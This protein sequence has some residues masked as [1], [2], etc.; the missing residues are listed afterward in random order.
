MEGLWRD[1]LLSVRLLR[2]SPIFTAAA[3][4]TLALGVAAN[5]AVFSVVNAFILRPLPVRDADRLVVLATKARSSPTL[6]G[7]SFPDVQDYRAATS[8]VFEDVTAYS[9]GFLGV[10]IDGDRP[11][12]V[13]VT[14][15]ADNYFPLLDLQPSLGRLI[16]PDEAGP[17]R[18]SAIVVLGHATWQRRFGSDPAVVGR[19]VRVNGHLCTIVGVAPP[20]F[21]G[22]FAFSDSELYL[23][24]DW[25][26]EG[27]FDNRGARGLHALARLRPGVSIA[28][29][30]ASIDVVAARLMKE[31]PVT[32]DETTVRVLP[33]RLARPEE[34]Q[35]RSNGWGA[36]IV[37]ILVGLV[38]GLAG[39]NVTSL[40]LARASSRQQ[41][42]ATRV[43]L[44]AGHGRLVRQM[45]TEGLLLAG[46]G[47]AAGIVIGT[48][49][50]DALA[51]GLLRLPGDLP[52]R[53][54][55]GLD[56]RVLAYAVV[57]ALGTG[58]AVSF[59]AGVR[60]VSTLDLT[61]RQ[62]GR[63]SPAGGGRRT[64]LTILVVQV[65]ACF[66]V[67]VAAGLLLRSLWAAERANLGFSPEGVLTVHMDVGQ[68]GYTEAEGRAFFDDVERRVLALPGVETASFAFTLPMGYIR[69]S[70][71]VEADGTASDVD[72][73]SAGKNIVSRRYFETLRIRIARGR[74]FDPA[75]GQR[76]RRVAVVNQCLA[77]TLWPGQDPVGRRFRSAGGRGAWI[78]VVGVTDTGKYRFLFEDPQP[79]FYVP[80]AQEYT[81]LRVLQ[82]RTPLRPE[83]LAPAIE[84][85]L[86]AREPN[87]TLYDV[88]SMAQALGGGLGFFLVRVGA[89]TAATLG[90]LG[91][92]LAIVGVYGVVAQATVQRRHEMGVRMALGA[93]R[94]D[95]LQLILR[96]GLKLL[97]LGLG[98]GLIIALGG[99]SILERFLFGVSS[100]DA[101]TF[102]VVSMILACV[103]MVACAIPAWHAT[104]MDP[105]VA[106]RTE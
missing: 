98:A 27:E 64:G 50:A 26:G 106:L 46:L 80:I 20:G 11:E 44:G 30:Q 35:A 53:F 47:A 56:W 62:S 105:T 58:L 43:S 5:V 48:W 61:L 9:V 3:A 71:T 57:V 66:V 1:L 60:A 7:V 76:S 24:L 17:G 32:N 63:R 41:E 59:L 39:A 78:E 52:V 96:D 68:L 82:V 54:D 81:G 90:L 19:A 91:L 85:S 40:L 95:I 101:A 51:A 77:D 34:D 86:L 36:A 33:E 100:R 13:L 94:R 74:S 72:R 6:R 42:F 102:A 73:V 4:L 10:T 104:R 25:S 45:V 18:P 21:R 103:T 79:Y 2:R 12:R 70:Q 31:H 65:A 16:R 55:F 22:T 87:L 49:A 92:A 89:A 93:T 23:P 29:A 38:M 28:Q 99:A 75:D 88:Q 8:D 83:I 37:L 97:A 69:V 15:V 84:R 14:W 67:L